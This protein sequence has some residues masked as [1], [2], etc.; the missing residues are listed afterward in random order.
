MSSKA[1]SFSS[2][3]GLIVYP[4]AAGTDGSE[5]VVGAE[6]TSS[7][8]F[9]DVSGSYECDANQA[10]MHV[11]AEGEAFD[12]SVAADEEPPGWIWLEGRLE[13]IGNQALLCDDLAA[14][15]CATGAAVPGIDPAKL[16]ALSEPLGGYFFGRV[17][18]GVIDELHYVPHH[19]RGS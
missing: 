2:P 3:S 9:R 16:D 7:P 1:R 14:A 8:E 6:G 10:V 19:V 15:D 11:P 13:A 5:V 17:G 12:P 18:D 4:T